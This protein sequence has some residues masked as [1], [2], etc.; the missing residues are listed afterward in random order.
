M[1]PRLD[2]TN[3]IRWV[4]AFLQPLPMSRREQNPYGRASKG[5]SPYT[6]VRSS[7]F[8][9]MHPKSFIYFRSRAIDTPHL[10]V[11]GKATAW[12]TPSSSK[13]GPGSSRPPQ[14]NSLTRVQRPPWLVHDVPFEKGIVNIARRLAV[15][16]KLFSSLWSHGS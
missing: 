1:G 15:H 10:I 13:G 2:L 6:K 12:Q 9:H 7:N 14:V 5:P 4:C 3:V 8:V 16:V 11:K